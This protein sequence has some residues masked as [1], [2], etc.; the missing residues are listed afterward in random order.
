MPAWW[1]A[2]QRETSA[3]CTTAVEAIFAPES[4]R[5][6]G[7]P[8][9]CNRAVLAHVQFSATCASWWWAGRGALLAER[10]A[11][12]VEAHRP[13]HLEAVLDVVGPHQFRLVRLLRLRRLLERTAES[14]HGCP[15][16]SANLRLFLQSTA[17]QSNMYSVPRRRATLLKRTS[18]KLIA[19]LSRD[20]ACVLL[21]WRWCEARRLRLIHPT[22]RIGLAA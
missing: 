9:F 17:N 22:R 14:G 18:A 12:L 20:Q 15:P 19:S 5:V 8:C 10:P 13:G 3:R 16:A 6:C 11:V 21:V 4:S 1:W 2:Q 7:R